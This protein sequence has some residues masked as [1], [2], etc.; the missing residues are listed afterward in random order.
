MLGT[1]LV[2]ALA[3]LCINPQPSLGKDN[4][5]L[6]QA[7]LQ[8]ISNEELQVTDQNEDEI[9]QA[10]HSLLAEAQKHGDIQDFD[11]EDLSALAEIQDEDVDQAIMIT[12]A[13]SNSEFEEDMKAFINAIT[14]I[15]DKD[16]AVNTQDTSKTS[17][18]EQTKRQDL[19]KALAEV[20]DENDAAQSEH[21]FKRS[22]REANIQNAIENEDTD[23]NTLAALNE[24]LSS[25]QAVVNKQDEDITNEV[26][27]S[28]AGIQWRRRRRWRPKVRVRRVFQKVTRVARKIKK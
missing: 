24:V 27:D 17:A 26:L 1:L 22:E 4:L 11:D 21:Q 13:G 7:K 3:I 15:E 23:E 16:M 19:I 8:K 6:N 28:M 5:N 9:E 20:K 2:M 18:K 14:G 25:K 12:L 10:L